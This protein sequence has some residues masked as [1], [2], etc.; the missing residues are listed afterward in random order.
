MM[1]LAARLSL[2]TMAIVSRVRPA[3]TS[4]TVHLTQLIDDPTENDALPACLQRTLEG[5]DHLALGG[6]LAFTSRAE[7][8]RQPQCLGQ[9]RRGDRQRGVP[10]GHGRPFLGDRVLN[11]APDEIAQARLGLAR[12]RGGEEH[13]GAQSARFPVDCG[14]RPIGIVPDLRGQESNKQGKDDGQRGKHA[15]RDRLEC[16]RPLAHRERRDEQVEPRRAYIDGPKDQ[17]L[18]STAPED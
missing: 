9:P 16:A 10:P 1:R 11:V 14:V 3:C 15:R 2:W 8:E 6:D 4:S 7:R 13:G 5:C 17:R 12:E 18:P